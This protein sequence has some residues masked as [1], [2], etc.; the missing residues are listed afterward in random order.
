V[1]PDVRLLPMQ[2]AHLDDVVAIEQRAH[3]FAWT[4]TNFIDSLAAGYSAQVLM[5]GARMLG[6]A[7]VSFA[8]DT[9]EL[10]NISIAPEF[11]RRG[12]GRYL[13]GE[14]LRQ[15]GAKGLEQMLLEVRM[16]NRSAQAL[17]EQSGFTRV[18]LRRNYYR[19]ANGGSED[20][21][22]MSRALQSR[23]DA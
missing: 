6:Y 12:W 1:S 8:V 18:G 7:I 14:L 13:L 2:P 22:V 5:D 21:L 19:A 11:Q 23:I 15:A 10:L 4:R 9:A 20:A 3:A 17:Y 16:S